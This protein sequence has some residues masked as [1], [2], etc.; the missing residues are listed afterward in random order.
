MRNRNR[1]LLIELIVR[2]IVLALAFV[3]RAIYQTL[4]GWW[5]DPLLQRKAN[6]SLLEDVHANLYFLF[7]E[8]Q[9]IQHPRIR[10]LPFDY[11]SVELT[12]GNLLFSF[13]RGREEVNVLVAPRH[14]PAMSYELG[15]VIAAL[16]N[17]RHSDRYSV[18]SL[19]DAA[20]LLQ[21]HLRTLNTA[22]SEEDFPIMKQKL[23]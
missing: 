1:Q 8:S 14:A 10:V 21:P 2:P 20:N 18:N 23:W 22:F 12:W 6:E 13:S 15:P 11:A 19:C 3:V 16:E 5:L 17:K 7:P 4:L 9:V